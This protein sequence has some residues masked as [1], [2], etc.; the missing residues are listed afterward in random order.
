MDHALGEER[1][2]WLV[3]RDHLRVEEHLHE[4]SRVEQMQNGVLNPTGVL[5]D[6][7]PVINALLIERLGGIVAAR[8]AHE[9]PG[10]VDKGIHCVRLAPTELATFRTG[11]VDERWGMRQRA[12][13]MRA[14]LH[15][16]RDTH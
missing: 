14:T 13:A 3:D 7:H 9:I 11:P 12:M 6:R 8:I 16:P 15:L 5:V 1:R 10:R 4:E 2:E